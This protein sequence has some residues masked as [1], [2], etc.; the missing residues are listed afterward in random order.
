MELAEFARQA[1][2]S[3]AK[4]LVLALDRAGWHTV[5]TSVK[6]RVPDQVHRRLLP[7]YAPESPPAEHLWSLTTAALLNQRFAT[8]EDL[9]DAQFA[10]HAPPSNGRANAFAPPRGSIGGPS[11]SSNDEA[12]DGIDM[13][14]RQ[15]KEK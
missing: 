14:Q 11:R 3:P 7:P 5:R 6:R 9:E 4:Q 10:W 8:L 15:R 13:S 12:Q 1:G 2:A